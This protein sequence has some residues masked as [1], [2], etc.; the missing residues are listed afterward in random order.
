MRFLIV[1]FA[2]SCAS[3]GLLAT[4]RTVSPGKNQ[5]AVALEGMAMPTAGRVVP[6]GNLS[7][8]VRFGLA[9][10]VDLGLS[11]SLLSLGADVRYQF[12]RAEVVEFTAGLAASMGYQ[13]LNGGDF[14]AGQP[15]ASVQ[16]PFFLG[17]NL[18]SHQLIVSPRVIY[19]HWLVVGG[20][21]GSHGLLVGSTVGVS[22]A[23]SDRFKLLP[24]VGVTKGVIARTVGPMVTPLPANQRDLVFHIGIGVLGG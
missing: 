5:V 2:T 18:G 12:V 23:L 15:V 24:F 7:G 11:A 22:L 13:L 19:E 10:R 3:S 16:V 21:V 8:A 20:V 4:A 9:D 1:L 14:I 6:A 17:F